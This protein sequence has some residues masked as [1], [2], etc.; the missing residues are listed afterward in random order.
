[1]V[2]PGELVDVEEVASGWATRERLAAVP[3]EPAPWDR[4]AADLL[5]RETGLG[6][7]TAALL[8]AGLPGL[9]SWTRDFLG[10]GVRDLLGITTAEAAAAREELRELSLPQRRDL[11]DAAVPDDL[12]D[13]TALARGLAAAWI[14][15]FGRRV[16]VPEDALAAVTTL[17]PDIPATRLLGL[18]V[19]P[20]ETPELTADGTH[21]IATTSYGHLYLRAGTPFGEV[22]TDLAAAIAWAYAFLPGGHPL[23]ARIPQALELARQRLDHD[24][25]LLELGAQHLGTRADVVKLFGDRPYADNPELVD[26]GLTVVSVEEWASLFFRPARLGQDTRSAALRSLGSG[27]VRAVDLLCSPGY[28]A[29]AER[30]AVLPD[31]SWDAD[32]RAGTPDLVAEAGK[33]LGVDEDPATLYLQLLTLLEPTDR[34]VRAWN[35][36]TPARHRKAG[37]VL[38]ERGLVVEAKRERAGRKLFLPGSWTKA[39]APNLPLESSKAELYDLSA[40]RFLPDRPL[41][42]LFAL[43]WEGTR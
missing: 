20:A 2:R 25:L 38:L 22:A 23:H 36:W 4:D 10:P 24:A 7:A 43:A 32:P 41:P 30:L 8:L 27:I 3:E 14:E 35:G 42:E 12:R 37:A 13:P 26:D 18:L 9:D 16:P 34:N 17:Q 40:S 11:L 39:K 31:G 21:T 33:V 1:A 15:R 5:A 19:A 28:A 29:I 6:R